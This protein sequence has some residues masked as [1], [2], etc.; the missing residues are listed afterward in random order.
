MAQRVQKNITTEIKVWVSGIEKLPWLTWGMFLW[1]LLLSKVYGFYAPRPSSVNSFELNPLSMS[2]D[3][4]HPSVQNS[5]TFTRMDKILIKNRRHNDWNVM[6]SRTR[7]IL[8]VK[9]IYKKTKYFTI[10]LFF[11]FLT[12]PLIRILHFYKR[13]PSTKH[14]LLQKKINKK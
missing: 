3:K 10:D 11:K 9:I 6:I 12:E 5:L 7:R 1:W 13:H 4:I 14:L 8:L 2:V